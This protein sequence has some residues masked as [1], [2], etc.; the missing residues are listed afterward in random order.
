MPRLPGIFDQFQNLSQ[1]TPQSL[2]PYIS[3]HISFQVVENYLANR[4]LYPQVIPLTAQEMEIDLSI[5]SE[6]VRLNPSFFYNKTIKQITIP[7]DFELHF[8]PTLALINALC[9]TLELGLITKI[10]VRKVDG[11]NLTGSVVRIISKSN[12]VKIETPNKPLNLKV[13]LTS[14][15]LPQKIATFKLNGTELIVY[16]GELGV[17]FDIRIQ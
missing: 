16:G 8:K 5:L 13:G 9:K 12:V 15:P 10:A 14:I 2:Q 17:I 6:A 4:F 11:T 3:Q 1:I 7:A